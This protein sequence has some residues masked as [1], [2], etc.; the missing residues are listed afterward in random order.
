MAASISSSVGDG[1]GD[2]GVTWVLVSGGLNLKMTTGSIME[3]FRRQ[4]AGQEVEQF[5]SRK[6]FKQA[7]NLGEWPA[8]DLKMKAGSHGG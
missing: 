6:P 5:N 8:D 1:K 3:A 2:V 4:E 7:A